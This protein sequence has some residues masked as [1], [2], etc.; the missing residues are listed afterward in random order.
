MLFFRIDTITY[1][2]DAGDSNRHCRNR[3]DNG[4][5]LSLVRRW[6]FRCGRN[7]FQR[8]VFRIFRGKFL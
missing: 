3:S 6:L 2:D 4:N 7:G 1:H 5:N 8:I